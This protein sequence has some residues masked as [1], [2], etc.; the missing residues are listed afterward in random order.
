MIF[1]RLKVAQHNTGL[2]IAALLLLFRCIILSSEK[3]GILGILLQRAEKN[4]EIYLLSNE[5]V[6]ARS[7]SLTPPLHRVSS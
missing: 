2:L 5:A 6:Y 3:R 1:M 4:E 7:G